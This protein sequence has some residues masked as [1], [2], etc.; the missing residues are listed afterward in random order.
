[1]LDCSRDDGSG[2]GLGL[3]AGQAGQAGV[4]PPPGSPLLLELSAE[5][6]QIYTCEAKN[7][8]VA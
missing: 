6:V 2:S 1:M 4:M 7:S 3:R 5:G 8:A